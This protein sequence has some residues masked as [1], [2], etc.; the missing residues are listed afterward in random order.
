MDAIVAERYEDLLPGY[1]D[2]ADQRRSRVN[3]IKFLTGKEA[4]RLQ[5]VIDELDGSERKALI[6]AMEK[7]EADEKQNLTSSPPV[8]SKRYGVN[9]ADFKILIGNRDARKIVLALV[10]D[11]FDPQERA[12]DLRILGKLDAEFLLLQRHVT[13]N[14]SLHAKLDERNVVLVLKSNGATAAKTAKTTGKAAKPSTRTVKGILRSTLA[15]DPIVV[16]T[17]ENGKKVVRKFPRSEFA[18]R[19]RSGTEPPSVK[20]EEVSKRLEKLQEND[21]YG[22]L[23]SSVHHPAPIPYGNLFASTYFLM[24]GFHALHVIIGMILFLI[25]LMPVSKLGANCSEWLENCGLYWHFVD[26]VWIFLF[27]LLYIV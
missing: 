25:P 2:T 8:F 20:M 17:I 15:A 27:P 6:A 7:R 1:N 23:I 5:K 21:E 19:P 13:E 16:E 12:K 4:V 11:G 14:V 22:E 18:E 24:T 9:E 26:L 10:D 3:A